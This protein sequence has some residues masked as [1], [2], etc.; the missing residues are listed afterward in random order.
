MAKFFSKIDLF[1]I[2]IFIEPDESLMKIPKLKIK[3]GASGCLQA[4]PSDILTPVSNNTSV[5]KDP[6]SSKIVAPHK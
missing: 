6:V 5:C 2:F 1:L 4:S 3:F